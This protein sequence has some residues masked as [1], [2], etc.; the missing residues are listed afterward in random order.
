MGA[1]DRS[2]PHKGVEINRPMELA[3]SLTGLPYDWVEYNGHSLAVTK[4]DYYLN[5]I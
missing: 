2:A 1:C 3:H 5:C 4:W